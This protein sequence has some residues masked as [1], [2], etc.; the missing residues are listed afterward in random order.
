MSHAEKLRSRADGQFKDPAKEAAK[1]SAMSMIRQEAE[2]TQEKTARLKALRM[3][4]EAAEPVALPKTKAKP[5]A[6][7][8]KRVS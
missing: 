5:A 2:K 6:R 1:G 8:T 4:Q 7:K 3:K